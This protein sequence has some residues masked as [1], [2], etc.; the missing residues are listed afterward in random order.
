MKTKLL[1][2][3]GALLFASCTDARWEKTTSFTNPRSIKCYSGEK[4]I[5]D[6]ISTGKISSEQNSDGYY[7]VDSKTKKLTEVSGNCVLV[8]IKE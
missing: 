5:Y 8:A 1:I 2:V 7:F 6:G 4:L 3:G